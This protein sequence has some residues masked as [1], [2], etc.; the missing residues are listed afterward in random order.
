MNE[1]NTEWRLINRAENHNLKC[2][3]KHETN[4]F[5]KNA[6]FK[7]FHLRELMAFASLSS[8]ALSSNEEP[9]LWTE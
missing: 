4:F 8:T 7:I 2:R 6:Y 1:E 9:S 3:I 5:L